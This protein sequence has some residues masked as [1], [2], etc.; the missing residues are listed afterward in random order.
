LVLLAAAV[1]GVSRNSRVL[2][3]GAGD[4]LVCRL[5][6]DTG[7]DAYAYDRYAKNF[8]ADGFSGQPGGAYELVCAIEVLE[9]LPDPHNEISLIFSGK[10]RVVIIS[11]D[12]YHGQDNAWSY[13]GP[14][15]GGHVFFY[16][17]K[18]IDLI[19]RRYGYDVS[20][21]GS[22][23]VFHREKMSLLQRAALALAMRPLGLLL[24]RIWLQFIRP[25]NKIKPSPA[26]L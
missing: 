5:L 2:D 10:P 18:A 6:R 4:G 12:R 20:N 19:A 14:D 8:Y 13:L 16:S 11:T 15:Q 22:S 23:A 25:Q 24:G 21:H 17:D 7:F 26:L 1:L 3:F 9:H